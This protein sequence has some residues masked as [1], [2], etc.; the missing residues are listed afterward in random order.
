LEAIVRKH[1]I[2]ID[3]GYTLRVGEQQSFHLVAALQ[4]GRFFVDDATF[5]QIKSEYI[6]Q[7]DSLNAF[8]KELQAQITKLLEPHLE[9]MAGPIQFRV[10]K[11]GSLEGKLETKLQ[12]AKSL[13]DVEDVVGLRVV[14]LFEP[15]VKTVCSLL[16]GNFNILKE[17]DTHTR[18]RPEE[19][20]YASIHFLLAFKKSW[21]RAP[22]NKPFRNFVAEVQVRTVSQHAWAAASH[23][24]Q[25]KPKVGVPEPVKRSIN[26]VSALLETV[27][28]EFKRVLVEI[29]EYQK[30]INTNSSTEKL[31]VLSLIRVLDEVLPPKNKKANDAYAELLDYLIHF[32][33]TTPSTLR[34]LLSE[35]WEAVLAVEM[36]SLR[37]MAEDPNLTEDDKSKLEKGIY[38]SHAG[39]AQAALRHKY[40]DSLE[41]YIIETNKDRSPMDDKDGI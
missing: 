29:A 13:R 31:N 22:T 15:D 23:V 9:R 33:I 16:K 10:K 20:G 17:E 32:G 30:R 26:R 21:L 39:W 24:L 7:H 25:Y 8:A 38:L 28:V 35:Q 18:L 36:D 19:F 4:H 37:L 11:W 1:P 2:A 41:K 40:G 3:A 27:D 34:S 6:E 12:D 5:A 14:T